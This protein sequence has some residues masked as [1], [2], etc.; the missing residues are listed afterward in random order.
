[1]KKKSKKN[2]TGQSVSNS[3]KARQ[4]KRHQER[5]PND[6]NPRVSAKL[7][8]SEKGAWHKNKPLKRKPIPIDKLK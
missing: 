4:L 2:P 6:K 3:N 7:A 1:M 8:E 5:N